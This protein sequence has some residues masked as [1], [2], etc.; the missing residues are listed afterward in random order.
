MVIKIK[1]DTELYV[2]WATYVAE[3]GIN[4]TE[5]FEKFI[6][7]TLKKNQKEPKIK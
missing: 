2:E 6:K 4:S 5:L 1:V 7:D 3:C